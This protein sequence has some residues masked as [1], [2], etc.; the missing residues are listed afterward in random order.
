MNCIAD[1]IPVFFHILSYLH[2]QSR[3]FHPHDRDSFTNKK[4]S[5]KFNEILGGVRLDAAG[6]QRQDKQQTPRGPHAPFAV[7]LQDGRGRG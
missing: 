1:I 5:N 6:S 7:D 4:H 2:L 3:N